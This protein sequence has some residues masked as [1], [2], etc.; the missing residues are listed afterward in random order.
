[1]KLCECGCGQ[2][3]SIAPRDDK[4]RGQIK[5]QPIRFVSGHHAPYENWR[6]K[7]TKVCAKCQQDLSVDAFQKCKRDGYQARCRKCRLEDQRADNEGHRERIRKYRA[8]NREKY[9]AHGK[10]NNAVKRGELQPASCCVCIRCGKQAEHYHHDSY[11]RPLDVTPVC[12]ACHKMI[13]L[14][15]TQ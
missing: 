13:H 10:V 4:R 8:A 14:E 9:V 6:S 2:P 15:M 12:S 11:D 5:G 1:M 3:T 7:V